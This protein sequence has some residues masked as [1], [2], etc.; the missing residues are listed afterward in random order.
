MLVSLALAIGFHFALIKTSVPLVYLELFAF[1]PFAIL[2]FLLTGIYSNGLSH[3]QELHRLTLASVNF[4]LVL[5]ITSFYLPGFGSESRLFLLTGWVIGLLLVPLGRETTRKLIAANPRFCEPAVVIG[6]GPAGY[7]VAEYLA[8]NP[9]TGFAPLVVVDRRIADRSIPS[10]VPVIRSAD[11]IEHPEMVDLFNG[12]HTAILVTNEINKEFL[13]LVVQEQT[14][15]FRHLL[16]ITKDRL[17][18]SLWLRPFEIGEILGLEIGQNLLNTWNKAAKRLIDLAFLLVTLPV[19]L[20]LFLILA[21][22][23]S[24]SSPG[25][26][27]TYRMRMGKNNTYYKKWKFRTMNPEADEKKKVTQDVNPETQPF[28]MAG[29]LPQKDIRYTRFGR[30][31]Y[32]SGFDNLPQLFNILK[33]EMSLIGPQALTDDEVRHYKDI[34]PL[35]AQALPGITGLWQ[36]SSRQ[37]S[38]LASRVHLDEYYIR[39]WSIWLDYYILIRTIMVLFERRRIERP[40]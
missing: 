1:I 24:L 25:K 23:I 12:I 4:F 36:V 15:K 30:F 28:L 27:I 5:I 38:S 32:Y 18:N 26:P 39:N 17:I 37:T 3:I 21:I 16:V 22:V 33:G 11:L 6:Y 35:F 40:A 34:Q 13:N 14:L 20:P 29:H 8:D 7:E 2:V 31:L 9:Q 19:T 10:R